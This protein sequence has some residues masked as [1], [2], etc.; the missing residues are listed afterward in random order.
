VSLH[1]RSY[2]HQSRVPQAFNPTVDVKLSGRVFDNLISAARNTHCVPVGAYTNTTCAAVI[3]VAHV[4]HDLPHNTVHLPIPASS[5]MQVPAPP[6]LSLGLVVLRENAFRNIMT[7]PTGR[8]NCDMPVPWYRLHSASLSTMP[9]T[10]PFQRGGA[11]IDVTP[12]PTGPASGLG[13]CTS[14]NLRGTE[15]PVLHGSESVVLG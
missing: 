14:L 15:P 11:R 7:I 10:A 3:R 8:R 9:H 1:Q 12:S 5:G 13:I 4:F 2:G 6:A